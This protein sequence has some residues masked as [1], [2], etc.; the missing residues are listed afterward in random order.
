LKHPG[1]TVKKE[2]VFLKRKTFFYLAAVVCVVLS[3]GCL[4][5]VPLVVT[6]GLEN[7]D[8]TCV[9]I[10]RGTDNIWGT[11]H[12]P[13]TDILAPGREAEVMVRP[14]V[15]DLQ[16]TDEDGDTYTVQGVRIGA[17][18]FNWTVTLDDIDMAT[19]VQ[20]AGHCAVAITNDL[21]NK[22]LSG[23]WLSP[24][25]AGDWGSNHINGE[26][27]YHGDTYTAYVQS[28]TYDIYVE[29]ESGNTY[30]VWDITVDGKGYT[31]L[32][33]MKDAD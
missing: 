32:V 28:D 33:S 2:A 8:I 24:S 20:Y 17:D 31:W 9:Y 4:E 6:N 26:R 15:Y 5:K 14:G 25:S 12:L 16:V 18:G 7:Y 3:T 1:K 19:A 22:T 29:D 11:N 21:D 10:S 30:T 27:L 13:D 23:V